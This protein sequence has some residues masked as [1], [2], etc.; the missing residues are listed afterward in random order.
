MGVLGV[1]Y[2]VFGHKSPKFGSCQSYNYAIGLIIF[3]DMLITQKDEVV[4]W[5]FLK[6]FKSRGL[7]VIYG[8]FGP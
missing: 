8:V 1:I 5:H 6:Y 3:W 7:G 4:M 2:G